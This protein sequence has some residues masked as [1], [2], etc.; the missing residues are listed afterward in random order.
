[1]TSEIAH[2]LLGILLFASPFLIGYGLARL[3]KR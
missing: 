1:M 3:G 2:L